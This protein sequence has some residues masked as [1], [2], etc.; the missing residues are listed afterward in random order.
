MRLGLFAGVLAFA[1]VGFA[2]P[3]QEPWRHLALAAQPNILRH[4]R[5]LVQIDTSNPPG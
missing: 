4:F 2:T 3:P 5:A 1:V